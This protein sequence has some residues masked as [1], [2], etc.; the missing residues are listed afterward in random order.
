MPSASGSQHPPVLSSQEEAVT[1]GKSPERP[2]GRISKVKDNPK[3]NLKRPTES[4]AGNA[5]KVLK[6]RQ[7]R[8]CSC[9]W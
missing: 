4:F 5:T 9:T 8:G 3:L 1:A 6:V 2:R 7:N